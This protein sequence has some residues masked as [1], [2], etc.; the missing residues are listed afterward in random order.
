MI[1]ETAHWR[2]FGFRSQGY[3][4]LKLCTLMLAAG[5]SCGCIT[6]Q[7][8][9]GH[10]PRPRSAFGPRLAPATV[11]D[12]QATTEKE[13]LEKQPSRVIPRGRYRGYHVR[14]KKIEADSSWFTRT[15]ALYLDSAGATATPAKTGTDAAIVGQRRVDDY[16]W[17][18][19]SY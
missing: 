18:F 11:E 2:P 13:E 7:Y 15:H 14:E 3:L 5:L 19:W 12:L 10:G 9:P 6:F 8:F 1:R 17:F 4:G 16:F